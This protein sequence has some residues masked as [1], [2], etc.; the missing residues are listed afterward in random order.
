V[1]PDAGDYHIRPGSAAKDTGVNAGVT[2]DIDGD[3]RT[4]AYPDIGADEL[5]IALMVTKQT[6]PDPVRPGARLTYTIRVTN[7]G[8]VTLTAT[9]TDTLPD[10]ITQGET[11]EGTLILPGGI[12]TWTAASIAPEEVWTKA[13]VVTVEVGSAG[14]LTN[15]VEVTT[16]E[17]ASG[18]YVHVLAP[19]LEVAKSASPDKARAGERLTYTIYLTNTGNFDLHATVTDTLPPQVSPHGI[20]TWTPTL[21]APHGIWTETVVVTVETG[22]VGL[23]TNVVEVTTQ[24]EARGVYTEV[25]SAVAQY[26]FYLPLALR[27]S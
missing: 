10:R 5:A 21:T 24:E 13:T 1:D 27:D 7:T 17:G 23:L 3:S 2:D 19:D 12:V 4:Y 26:P 18:R 8:G 14:P 9:I 15:V 6:A 25:S 22:Y 16:E 11:S 20:L